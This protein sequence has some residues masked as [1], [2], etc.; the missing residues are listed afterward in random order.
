MAQLELSHHPDTDLQQ[1]SRG[2]QWA[3]WVS[4]WGVLAVAARFLPV[5]LSGLAALVL[6]LYGLRWSG[7]LAGT[8]SRWRLLQ[9]VVF[10]A[11]VGGTWASF[12]TFL[13]VDAGV[14]FLVVCLVAKWLELHQRRDHDVAL[15]LSLFVLASLFLFDQTLTNAVP[16]L[17]G[18]LGTL[19]ALG[20]QVQSSD[21]AAL[22]TVSTTVGLAIPLMVVLFLFMPR[23]PPLWSVQL[24]GGQ[25]KT[26][27]TDEI[28]PGDVAKLSQSSELA[29]R[30]VVQEGQLP[31]RAQLYWRGL[32]MSD[33]D[34]QRWRVSRD[35]RA[36]A[37][38]V[39]QLTLVPVWL[40]AAVASTTPQLRYQLQ[41]QRTGQPWL[42]SLAVPYSTEAGV[43]VNRDLLLQNNAPLELAQNFVVMQLP[44]SGQSGPLPLWERQMNVYLPPASNP[45]AQGFARA[46]WQRVGQDPQ[47]YSSAVLGWIRTQNFYYTLQPPPLTGARID[48]FLFQT[49]QGFCE[50]YA[51]AYAFLMRAAGVPARL[52][53][54]YQ[55]GQRGQDG[56]S[57]EVR[58][59]DAHA[60]VE[61][62]L[63][64]RGWVRV[65]PTAAIAPERIEQGMAELSEQQPQLFGEGAAGLL[66]AQQ[67][68]WMGQ[69]RQWADY[70][71]YLWQ[72][73]VVGFDQNAQQGW[74]SRWLG[75][76][77]MRQQL[78]TLGGLFAGGVLLAVGWLWWQRRPR[79]HPV[80][81]PVL[82][83][84]RHLQRQGL[85]GR[86]PQETVRQ[87]LDRV[88]AAQPQWSGA[89][90]GLV[91]TYEQARYAPL[92]P[93]QI[94]PLQRQLWQ[95][96]RQFRRALRRID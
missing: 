36:R 74:L 61:I 38:H 71:G 96:V 18:T 95:Q 83:L 58:Q 33:F 44:P 16:V 3:L 50:H 90:A 51:S 26:G 64:G 69:A 77:S 30:V 92:D 89:L 63:E 31:Q 28:Q 12:R 32:V 40:Q 19:W 55:G 39:P 45:Q 88:G 54:G 72:R 2:A 56:Q 48:Q 29:F 84:S 82:W 42:F 47:R 57:W 81:Q 8:R 13:G 80:D 14:A 15:N 43:R 11:G 17:L 94:R 66:R 25:G 75:I 9:G 85:P 46:L 49:R 79:L 6:V 86:Q 53:A 1:P 4:Q 34:G 37:Y 65:D 62:W 67:F 24:A 35:E 41:M 60:W 68:R 76:E 78:L 70:V 20:R 21:R 5:W 91:L 73:D 93:A 10:L 22:A 27:M 23:L 52:V 87:W 59:M 7:R